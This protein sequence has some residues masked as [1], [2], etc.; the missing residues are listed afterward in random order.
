MLWSPHVVTKIKEILSAAETLYRTIGNDQHY[1]ILLKNSSELKVSQQVLILDISYI[2][3][4][5]QLTGNLE[6]SITL[7]HSMQI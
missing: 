3:T 5:A 2:A 7:D 6:R 4:I 1:N